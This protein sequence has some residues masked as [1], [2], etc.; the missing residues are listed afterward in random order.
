[1]KRLRD[2][3]PR[4]G[5][6]H[7]SPHRGLLH[8]LA[9]AT[10]GLWALGAGAAALTDGSVGPT[11]S[12][13]GSFTVPQGLG[14]VRG[15]NL[16]HSFTRFDIARSESAVFTT[17]DP[18]LRHVIT[19]V[20]GGQPS[21]IDG[22][23]RLDAAAGS[24][25]A[26]WFI[27]PSGVVV[28]EGARLDVPGSLHLSTA[29]Q[30][31]MADGSS[32][33]ARGG[34]SSLSVAAPEAFGFLGTGAAPLRWT[35]ANLALQPGSTLQLAAGDVTVDRAI[36]FAPEGHQRV[37]AA[38]L[39]TLRDGAQLQA[40]VG[41]ATGSG[42]I[43]VAAGGM[44]L[45]STSGAP[46]GLYTLAGDTAG[47]VQGG[48]IALRVQ[49][50]VELQGSA[51]VVASNA[52]AHAV[53][54]LELQAGSLVMDGG[55]GVASLASFVTGAGRGAD[56]R[57]DVAGPMRLG[58]GSQ[59]YAATVGT[60]A[61]GALH[62]QADSLRL[63]GQEAFAFVGTQSL[64]SA[65]G[66]AGPLQLQVRGA[67]SVLE[68]GL[69]SS[70]NGAAGAAGPM[71]ISAGS[72][73]LDGGTAQGLTGVQS[74]GAAPLRVQVAGALDVRASASIASV[75][76]GLH[77]PKALQ[78]QAG[79]VHLEGGPFGSSIHS[80]TST[81]QPAAPVR[82]QA[83][84]HITL[85][86]AGQISSFTLGPGDAGDV[87]VQAPRVTLTGAADAPAVTV[88]SSSSLLPG[89]GRSGDVQIDAAQ[90]RIAATA[91]VY[92]DSL[93]DTGRAGTV[94]ARADVIEIDG[95]GLATGLRS[96]AQG[97]TADAGRVV[98]QA[99]QSLIVRDG[100]SIT[101]GA[102]GQ[103]SPGSI[104]VS[105]PDLLLDGQGALQTFTG[106]A[107]DVLF[108]AGVGAAV[109][110]K[111]GTLRIRNGS[112]ISS[113]TFTAS[114]AGPVLVSADVLQIDGGDRSSA[115]GIS[116]D[117]G[118][119]GR[120]GDVTIA[121]GDITL[122]NEALVSSS[123]LSTG[124]GGSIRISGRSLTIDHSAGLFTVTAG[125]ASAGDIAVTLTDALVM[126]EGAGI[127]ANTGGDGAAGRIRISAGRFEASGFDTLS[128]FR[129]QVIS[130]ARPGS[131][132]QPGSLDIDVRDQF[133]L[134]DG[135][136]LSIA[137]DAEL[138][139]PKTVT[140]GLLTLRAGQV[141]LQDSTITAAASANADAGSI[142][143]ASGGRVLLERSDVR[144]SSVDGDGGSIS[145]IS[146]GPVQLRDASLTSSVDGTRNG[147]GGD[148][149][150]SAPALVMQSGF[151]QAN[152]AAPLARGGRVQVQVGLLV[153]DGSHLFVGGDRI[154]SFRAGV[155]GYNVVQAAAP[156][157]VSGT[158][159]LT[160]PQLDLSAS[161]VGLSSRRFDLDGIRRDVCEVGEDSSFTTPGRGAVRE[162]ASAPLRI[163]PKPAPEGR[164]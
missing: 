88:I 95:Q 92:A 105:A 84:D 137:N 69:I 143:L 131:G 38:G 119:A 13:S 55:T 67:L 128:G 53:G 60:G 18:G 145:L 155:P 20:T 147:N 57:I 39:L 15:S 28:G 32:W 83:A 102:F 98:V 47:D 103:G 110:V 87:Q 30:L 123:A 11:Q 40:S 133:T 108:G 3:S 97:S 54:P 162:P 163:D 96:Q 141:L 14:S 114:D 139:D 50:T 75:S 81:M 76:D 152:T 122:D 31:R 113:S 79:S 157:G 74:F 112:S 158:L 66:D 10:L 148:L 43:A 156:D 127:T 62:L 100:G 111:A 70:S 25:P 151:V 68:A 52:S 125:P 63:D 21:L 27:N 72:M 121:A 149:S 136:A 118:G 135:A 78:V 8:P 51:E 58:P 129:T 4:R 17:T 5:L 107:G 48:G 161:L 42:S 115:T 89:A 41:P 164:R 104:E 80:R 73:Q 138:A 150:I 19:R 142:A 9:A 2:T 154:Q 65:S 7:T 46:T 6:L 132:G 160:L 44:A 1:M 45:L 86:P 124:Q 22:G 64:P 90:L 71:D 59:A 134:R 140:P 34:G 93:S 23:L 117:S 126:R 16:F 12:L 61:S 99:R 35:G 94:T 36:L 130:R 153:P 26:F 29:Q 49:G 120:A 77:A 146:T 144:T 56:V 116:A 85:G 24:R 109:T 106:I 82:V 159:E 37:Q 91:S 33:D 101:A